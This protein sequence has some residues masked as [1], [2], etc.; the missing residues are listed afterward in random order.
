ML[1]PFSLV[2]AVC[3]TATGESGI[4]LKGGLPWHYIPKEMKHFANTTSHV[5][6]ECSKKKNAVVMGRKTWE[7]IP[8]GNR[9]LKNRLN[10]VLTSQ[11]D[12]LK[13]IP[14]TI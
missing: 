4:G 1:K 14:G 11:S 12:Y 6:E 10:V 3:K 5:A 9:P 7:S 13:E 2:V 8:E